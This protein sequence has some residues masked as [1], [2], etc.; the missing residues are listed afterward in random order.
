MGWEIR[1]TFMEWEEEECDEEE[2][3]HDVYPMEEA[4]NGPSSLEF[5]STIKMFLGE[6][7]GEEKEGESNRYEV[8]WGELPRK[9]L[10]LLRHRIPKTRPYDPMIRPTLCKPMEK[11]RNGE[12]TTE[13]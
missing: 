2:E 5:I 6:T 9:G 11:K 3:I 7:K 4:E 13:S 1:N 8:S 12:A 10:Y